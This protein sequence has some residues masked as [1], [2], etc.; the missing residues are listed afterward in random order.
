MDWTTIWKLSIYVWAVSKS[1]YS[2]EVYFMHHDE[3]TRYTIIDSP[4]GQLILAGDFHNLGLIQFTNQSDEYQIDCNWQYSKIYF[5]DATHQLEQYFR[6]ELK[7]FSIPTRLSGTKFQIDVITE[8][9][10]IPYGE[11]CSYADLAKKVGH[12][13][14]YRAVG[15]ANGY[16]PLPIIFPCHRVI[17]SN[18]GIGG[19]GGGLKIKE[20][21]LKLEA[22]N[23]KN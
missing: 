17:A 6:G 5:S 3:I 20:A 2:L 9:Q 13:R 15:S 14:A 10:K 8:L 16:N 4:I 1:D 23:C 22:D 18:G 12:P 21:L 7:Q 19:Y 11:T